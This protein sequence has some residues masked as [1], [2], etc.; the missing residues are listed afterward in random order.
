MP[1]LTDIQRLELLK[2]L[3][4]HVHVADFPIP[5]GRVAVVEHGVGLVPEQHRV[6]VLGLTE[7]ADDV[8]LCL[9]DE[10]VL[11]ASWPGAA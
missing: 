11:P 5:V 9:A 1:V 7:H 10:A 2:L 4:E 3:Q 6:L 8:L